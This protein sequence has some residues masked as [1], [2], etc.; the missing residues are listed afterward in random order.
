MPHQGTKFKIMICI[1]FSV[2]YVSKFISLS[3]Y[4]YSHTVY[5]SMYLPSYTA[6]IW[7]CVWPNGKQKYMDELGYIFSFRR[8]QLKWIKA[9]LHHFHNFVI[10]RNIFRN[11]E[12]IATQQTTPRTLGQL[13][14]GHPDTYSV[15]YIKLL[16]SFTEVKSQP[17]KRTNNSQVCVIRQAYKWK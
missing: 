14:T 1:S 10:H 8:E 16:R 9:S 7:G 6:R 13:S 11:T 15:Y 4:L 3:L 12:K 2:S 5:P 17:V